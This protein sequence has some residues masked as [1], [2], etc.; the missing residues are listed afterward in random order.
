ML[1]DLSIIF[2]LSFAA[3][4]ILVIL[5]SLILLRVVRIVYQLQ[6]TASSSGKLSG[7]EAPD[8]TS[9]DLSGVAISS[10]DFLGHLT[11]LLFVSPSCQSCMTTL[12]DMEYLNYKAQGNV[13]VICRAGRED[14][15]R[16]A[17]QYKVTVP[18]VADE[19][20]DISR[21]YAISSVP[22]AI[23]INADRRIQSYGRPDREKL[24]KV[25]ET[26]SEEEAQGVG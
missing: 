1:P 7:K 6:Q 2:Y 15:A 12:E 16:L 24:E 14:C 26:A 11:L 3:L 18:V 5:H 17:E 19:D 22:T 25:L 10:T 20:D 9:V 23:L 4:W 13:I 21:L 8:F